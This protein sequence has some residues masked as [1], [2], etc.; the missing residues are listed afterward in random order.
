M[1]T[2][3]I[4][5]PE[6]KSLI[7]VRHSLKSQD[8]LSPEG[9][10]L[11]KKVG[12]TQLAKIINQASPE[13]LIIVMGVSDANRTRQTAESMIQGLALAIDK[14]EVVP[15]TLLITPDKLVDTDESQRGSNKYPA[16]IRTLNRLAA[17]EGRGAYYRY[18][19]RVD[20]QG[21]KQG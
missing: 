8:G 13:S 12:R 4:E 6:L 21:G 20:R 17:E 15:D 14:D 16:I 11:A 2:K 5:S 3:E 1:S 10:E 9:L 19:C 18:E 7:A